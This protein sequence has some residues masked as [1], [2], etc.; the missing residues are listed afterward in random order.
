MGLW[1]A[2]LLGSVEATGKRPS[3]L[4][5]EW[6]I[7]QV[8]TNSALGTMY[9]V[10]GLVSRTSKTGL[11]NAGLESSKGI[12]CL[13]KI[14]VVVVRWECYQRSDHVSINITTIHTI[15]ALLLAPILLTREKFPSTDRG[16]P[17]YE[18]PIRLHIVWIRRPI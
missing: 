12:S 16:T 7:H 17:R 13:G 15:Q 1:V 3:N 10:S 11:S 4:A 6:V 2:L 14:C 5:N 8:S 9:Q 18:V